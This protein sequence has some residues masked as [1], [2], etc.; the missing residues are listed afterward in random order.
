MLIPQSNLTSWPSNWTML[1]QTSCNNTLLDCVE[2]CSINSDGFDYLCT[3]VERGTLAP[4]ITLFCTPCDYASCDVNVSLILNSLE[5]I[6][7]IFLSRIPM[8][9]CNVT[10][11]EEEVSFFKSC[12]YLKVLSFS[13]V[14]SHLTKDSHEMFL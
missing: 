10:F 4:S 11:F 8:R 14:I 6:K 2:E 7:G 3:T 1:H 12:K 5:S 13:P 9:D